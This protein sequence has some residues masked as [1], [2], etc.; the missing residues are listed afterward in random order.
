MSTP[1]SSQTLG[2]ELIGK[3]RI[4]PRQFLIL[5][6]CF[7]LNMLDGF[8]VTVMAFTAPPIG[9]EFGI[10]GEQLAIAFSAALAGM[11]IG[12][13][14]LAP[15][16]DVIGRR[17]T[18]LAGVTLIGVT[19]LATPVMPN[20]YA[21][22]VMRFITGLG[23]GTLLASLAAIATE[24]M[25][26]RYRSFGVTAITA[27]YPFAAAVGAFI[28][29][30]M[31]EQFGWRSVF[32]AG[33]AATLAMTILVF[34]II[35]ESL[36]Y[37]INRRP[38]RAKERVNAILRSIG[39]EELT[40]LPPVT[41]ESAV[42]PGAGTVFNNMLKLL[43]DGR[44]K[45]TLMVWTTFFFCFISLYFLMSWIPKLVV[46]A[47]GSLRSGIYVAS[48]FNFGG[49]TGIMFLGWLSTR[50]PLTHLIGV[51]M[52]AASLLMMLF[53]SLNTGIAVMLT[54]TFFIGVLL[55]GGFTG[56]YAVAAKVYPAEIR[57]TGV[58]WAIGLGRFGA[59]VGPYIGGI[60]ID[61][62]YS[63]AAAFAIF[64]APLMIGGILAWL[65]R[66]R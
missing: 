25:P 3:G 53:G 39:K 56:M 42:R 48:A 50:L 1:Q 34:L 31:I 33:G 2:A 12:A 9:D 11:M 27:G 49:F 28:A 58:G 41:E 6:V 29:A 60:L 64:G 18:I 36:D 66:V 32:Y 4:S 15:V 20:I 22:A 21:I 63:M 38:P 46:D 19:M 30:P 59:V 52:I 44:A 43:A 23:V 57:A 10:G 55:Q 40:E 54:L 5:G 47:G 16:S 35:P 62:Q 45:R 26:E 17:R 61:L 65:I 7:V 24:Y 37:L 8:D 14:F 51:F 13:M